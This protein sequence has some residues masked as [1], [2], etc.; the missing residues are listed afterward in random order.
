MK[1]LKTTIKEASQIRFNVAFND[2]L[3]KEGLPIGATILVDREN[4]KEFTDFLNKEEGNI[5]AHAEGNGVEY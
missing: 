3:D 4:V 2:L 5:F 1:T